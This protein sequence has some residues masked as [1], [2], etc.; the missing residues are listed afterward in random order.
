ML[1][2]IAIGPTNDREYI[3]KIFA[4]AFP[5]EYITKQMQKGIGREKILGILRD[6][7]RHTTVKAL[8]ERRVVLSGKGDVKL[9]KGLFKC[10]FRT[11]LNNWLTTHAAKI[12]IENQEEVQEK[13]ISST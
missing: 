6:K 5:D 2:E 11:K 3:N 9:R 7:K 4:V 12:Q 1:D 13:L 10:A 8:Y